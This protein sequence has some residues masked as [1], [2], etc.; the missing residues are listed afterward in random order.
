MTDGGSPST[1]HQ[2]CEVVK[3][4]TRQK[5]EF[6]R[7]YLAV[8]TERV[9]KHGRGA[10]ELSIVDLFAAYGWCRA[11]PETEPGAPRDPWPGSAIL[12]VRALNSYP[13]P[14]RLVINS[15]DRL[16]VGRSRA[17]AEA[18]RHA[19]DAERGPEPR[20]EVT[21]T[22]ADVEE[23]A[24]HASE[25]VNLAY[26]TIWMLDPYYPESLPWTVVEMIAQ[27]RR[28]YKS[29][30]GSETRRP[31]L[32]VTLMTEGLQRNVD[33][34][35]RSVDLAL[36]METSQWRHRLEEL[37]AEGANIRQALTYIYAENLRMIYG[38]WPTVLEV[39]A[40]PGNIVYALVL[41]SS[42]NA[43]TF[44]PKILVKPEFQQW[45]LS[46]WKPTARLITRNR[47]F[48]RREGEDAPLQRS[49]DEPGFN[50]S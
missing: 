24:R 29:S 39:D 11:N 42:H 3:W 5:H 17:Q 28:E 2:D 8:W 12:S 43:G 50:V 48:R 15:Y 44:V 1:I 49:L 13:R 32:I 16:V 21:Y 31:E 19:V 34:S 25:V 23:A 36:G 26:P 45:R 7:Q 22:S 4:H 38:Q 10:P 33:L 27:L 20:Y 37:K 14:G 46:T 30:K 6:I 18:V 47:S 9:A 40:S 41:C 35:P